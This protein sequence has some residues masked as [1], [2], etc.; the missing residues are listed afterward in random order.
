[1]NNHQ[2]LPSIRRLL[3]LY[4]GNKEGPFFVAM[5]AIH[6]NEAAG[7]YALKRVFRQ[8]R[9][10][11]LPFRGHFIGLTGNIRAAKQGKR[12]ID[13]D[14]NRQWHK[15]KTDSA[16]VEQPAA[17]EVKVDSTAKK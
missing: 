5:G 14:L 4:K 9:I 6:G 2:A 16:T 13:V 10:L 15:E 12:F 8:L 3:G 7:I 17:A 11:N 1:M